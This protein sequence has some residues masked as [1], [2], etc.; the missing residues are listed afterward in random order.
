MDKLDKLI[1]EKTKDIFVNE[2]VVFD[3]AILALI[4]GIVKAAV[5]RRNKFIIECKKRLKGKGDSRQMRICILKVKIE[6]H[7]KLIQTIE[8]HKKT[9]CPK[10]NNPEKCIMVLDKKLRKLKEQLDSYERQLWKLGQE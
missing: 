3:L 6:T 10:Q 1:T 9:N 4:A 5:D 8:G 7:K 2:L